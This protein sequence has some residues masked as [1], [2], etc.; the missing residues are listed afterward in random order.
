MVGMAEIFKTIF[1]R[2]VWE[3]WDDQPRKIQREVMGIFKHWDCA[4]RQG[5][6]SG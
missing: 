4:Q 2:N 6:E 5:V 1:I 3:A